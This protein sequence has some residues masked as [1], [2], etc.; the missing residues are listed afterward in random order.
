MRVYFLIL[1]GEGG[2]DRPMN[3]KVWQ[4]GRYWGYF[5]RM[6]GG[7]VGGGLES[8]VAAEILYGECHLS[9][10]DIRQIRIICSLFPQSPWT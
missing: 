3:A 5:A 8:A 7:C 6:L 9:L 4:T 2:V 10:F 1:I